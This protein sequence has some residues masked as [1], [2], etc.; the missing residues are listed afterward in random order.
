RAELSAAVPAAAPAADSRFGSLL[1]HVV[2]ADDKSPAA[3]VGVQIYQSAAEDYYHDVLLVRTGDDGSVL[4]DPIFAGRITLLF[5][6]GGQGNAQVEAGK[7]AET[8]VEIPLGFDLEGHVRAAD[9]RTVAGADIY[10]YK[11]IGPTY[12]GS[13]LAHSRE[14]GS[15]FVRSIGP[16]VTYVSA[17]AAGRAPTRQESVVSIAG[18]TVKL[19]IAFEG[20]GGGVEGRVLSSDGTPLSGAAIVIHGDEKRLSFEEPAAQRVFTDESGRFRF[21]SVASG[22]HSIQARVMGLAPWESEVI[23]VA[24]RTTPCDI[25]L[26]TGAR[27]YGVVRDENGAP[28]KGASIRVG[29]DYKIRS[30][31]RKTSQDGS[32]AFDCVPLGEFEVLVEADGQGSVKTT[33]SGESGA[34]LH[35]DAVLTRGLV[36]R[37][38]VVAPGREVAKW[39]FN[40]RAPSSK[41]P[42]MGS[43][44]SDQD[45]R[46]EVVGC[47]DAPLRIEA[48]APHGGY[49]PN[50]IVENVQAGAGEVVI[51]PDPALEPSVRIQGRIVDSSDEPLG[52]VQIIPFRRGSNTSPGLASDVQ[53]G[54][55]EFGPCPPGDWTLRIM[56]PGY[57]DLVTETRAL[58][59]GA[60]WNAGDLVLQRGGQLIASVR[61]EQGVDAPKPQFILTSEDGKQDRLRLDG[62]IARSGWV[63]SGHYKLSI[64]GSGVALTT[65]DLEV[66]A[67]EETRVEVVLR[68]GVAVKV[69]IV[70]ASGHPPSDSVKCE[71]SDARG[72]L[73][74]AELPAR[75]GSIEWSGRLLPGTYRFSA[76]HADGRHGEIDVQVG[77]AG[78]APTIEREL[79]I[80]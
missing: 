61:R 59:S 22:T 65:Q 53:T 30:A 21:N 77:S 64:G 69:H 34:T 48:H 71:I 23:V 12:D 73:V 38:R 8:T 20:A 16:G 60:T 63:A 26:K 52:G 17:R 42:F 44:Q 41:E 10:V 75:S 43:A 54:N 19:D 47:P 45:G 15:Y 31:F 55:F 24:G 3:N 74:D 4:T 46:F 66:R 14:D 13:I 39:W 76:R 1:L 33:L 9:G 67:D 72:R 28:V 5:D 49:W 2:W 68:S 18:A 6:R 27:L 11:C 40:I 57:A 7:Q 80:R 25:T 70:D 79:T 36:L 37:G 35:W 56:S 50:A 78:G 32:F 51:E 58:A 29:G 62:D